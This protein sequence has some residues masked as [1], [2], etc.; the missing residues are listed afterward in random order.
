MKDSYTFKI[1]IA[2]E[3]TE[4][5]HTI[6]DS[7]GDVSIYDIAQNVKRFVKGQITASRWIKPRTRKERNV[8]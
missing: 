2:D 6:T 1:R 5:E 7:R 3:W 4:W 8:K